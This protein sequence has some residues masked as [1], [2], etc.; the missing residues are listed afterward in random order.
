MRAVVLDA[1]LSSFGS[2]KDR[3]M[4]FRVSTPEL[5]VAE[6]VA[7][8]ELEGLNVRLLIEPVDYVPEDKLTI[9]KELHTKTPGQRLR[10]I[11]FVQWKQIPES[12]D[13]IIFEQF[14]SVVMDRICNEQKAVLE[15]AV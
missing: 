7:L 2:R 4:G 15:Q 8:M 9:K 3:S 1:I 14:Y 13:K 5:A 6:K 12:P 10:A 11:L